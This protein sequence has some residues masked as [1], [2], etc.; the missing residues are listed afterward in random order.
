MDEEAP[1]AHP[2]L[3]GSGG[4]SPESRYHGRATPFGG[5]N[6]RRN[7][8]L[9]LLFVLIG[10]DKAPAPPTPAQAVAL[11]LARANHDATVLR[12]EEDYEKAI[13]PAR[14]ARRKARAEERAAY[15]EARAAALA[16][17]PVTIT[18]A[19]SN[20][21]KYT[22]YPFAKPA[23]SKKTWNGFWLRSV[24]WP[25]RKSAFRRNSKRGWASTTF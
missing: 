17:R 16:G 3:R 1:L 19:T 22:I 2:L 9:A 25:G 4:P 21:A 8:A 11:D 7:I 24:F 5:R 6:I 12:L 10:C 23:P 15:A 13:A 20:G 14:A 18:G